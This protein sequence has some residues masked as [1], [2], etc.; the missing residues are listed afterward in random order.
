MTPAEIYFAQNFRLSTDLLRGYPPKTEEVGSPEDYLRKV[1][2]KMEEIN[3]GI[4]KQIDIK[5]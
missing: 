2:R 1:K 4:R 3:K 5:S